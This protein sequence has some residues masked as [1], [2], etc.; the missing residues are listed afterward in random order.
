[1]RL[2]KNPHQLS[3]TDPKLF[4][5]DPKIFVGDPPRVSLETPVIRWRSPDLHWRNL[6]FHYRPPDFHWRPQIFVGD[7]H[8]FIGDSK[9][10]GV[11]DE[12]FVSPL[13]ILVVS[14]S[15]SMMMISS[16]TPK[17]FSLCHKLWFSDPC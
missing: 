8:I 13:K 5:E 3:T 4:I 16:L 7:P 15:T 14:N 2:R 12:K 17:E 9:Q 6:D 1:M 10:I 11:S